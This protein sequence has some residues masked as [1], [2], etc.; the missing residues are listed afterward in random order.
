M[1]GFDITALD[2]SGFNI[3]FTFT[4][5]LSVSTGINPDLLLLQIQMEQF[6]DAEGL[7]LRLPASI[8]KYIEIPTQ[9][10]DLA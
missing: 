3:Q 9:M 6:E 8:V 4:D 1:D 7:G 5:P 10:A 2:G